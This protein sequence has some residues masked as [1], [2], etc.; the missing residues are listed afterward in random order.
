M[1][2]F[3]R[4]VLDNGIR[5]LV[6]EVAEASSVS[7][8]ITVVGGSRREPLEL[9][10]VT[11]FVE[12]MLF[13]G[14]RRRNL[15]DLAREI[16]LQGGGLDAYTS[17]E[18]LRLYSR[19]VPHD[20]ADL[21]TMF[22]EMLWE[23]T[24]PEPEIERERG[25]IL[26]EIAE[27]RDN[28]EDLCFDMFLDALWAP[29]PLGRP[30]LGLPETVEAFDRARLTGYWETTLDPADVIISLAGAITPAQAVQ[31]VEK[32]F[33]Y[34]TRGLAPQR[35]MAPAQPKSLRTSSERDTEQVQFCLGHPA[36]SAADDRRFALGLL[37]LVLGGG[38]GSRLFNEIREKRGLAY[39]IGSAHHLYQS[40]GYVVIFGATT[41]ANAEEVIGLCR[42]EV[43]RIARLGPTPEELSVAAR[44]ALRG[45]LL[46]YES[47]GYRSTRNAD[48]EMHNEERLQPAE[49]ERRITAVT[50]QDVAELAGDLFEKTV[51]AVSMVG[52]V[53]ATEVTLSAG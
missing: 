38:M 46:A 51:E 33:P 11:H 26:E 52:P 6:E 49:V 34:P 32:T 1:A 25:V 3:Q 9:G 18:C 7:A 17:H 15:Y 4:I 45:F 10:G 27:C 43:A 37:N 2:N 19:V 48:R 47:I 14:T 21:L 50:L 16:N 8:G 20:L 12:H 13:K 36:L 44:Q 22:A 30:I 31:L 42:E 53:S 28:P 39:T 41:A 5:L 40:E 24:F 35:R 29:D 23:S